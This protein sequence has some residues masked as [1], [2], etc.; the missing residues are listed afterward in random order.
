MQA[1]G[2][3]RFEMML[4]LAT[5]TVDI[6]AGAGPAAGGGWIFRR[7]IMDGEVGGA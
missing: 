4:G 1:P 2:G 3:I 6:R 5:S 7:R